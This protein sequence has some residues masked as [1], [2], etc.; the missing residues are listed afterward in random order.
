[1]NFQSLKFGVLFAI[2]ILSCSAYTANGAAVN[3]GPPPDGDPIA[4]RHDAVSFTCEPGVDVETGDCEPWAHHCGDAITEVTSFE[5][6]EELAI[7]TEELI[8]ESCTQTISNFSSAGFRVD[9]MVTRGTGGATTTTYMTSGTGWGWRRRHLKDT[10]H[11][12]GGC[13]CKFFPPLRDCIWI[14]W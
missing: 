5:A 13:W 7:V 3:P 1:M 14:C 4:P 10:E 11:G 8:G 6:S 2:V 12:T 9:G